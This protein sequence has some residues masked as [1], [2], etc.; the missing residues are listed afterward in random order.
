MWPNADFRLTGG[1]HGMSP[2][3]VREIQRE[4]MLKAMTEV[5]ARDGYA[6]SEE[7]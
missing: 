6:W 2:E 7:Q 3:R 1:P 4:R 5:V